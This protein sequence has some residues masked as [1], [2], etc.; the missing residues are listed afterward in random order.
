MEPLFT[1]RP[2]RKDDLPTLG[3]FAALEGMDAIPSEEGVTVAESQAGDVVGFVRIVQGT[4]PD[5]T[6]AAHVNPVV[7]YS[8]WRGYGV[9][10]ALVEDAL[11]RYG[12]LRLVS[13]GSSLGFYRSLG[14][15]EVPWDKI[16]LAVVDDCA[17][18]GMREECGPCPVART[19]SGPE[20]GTEAEA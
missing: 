2:A 18:C 1:L 13:R 7:V 10:R 15:R 6:A 12:E 16:D 3:M 8:S 4:A 9:G 11:V 5:G 14:F 20:A 19:A 17:G